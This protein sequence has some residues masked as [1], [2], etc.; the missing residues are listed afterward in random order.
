[1]LN[2][3]AKETQQRLNS[4]VT[5][6]NLVALEKAVHYCRQ[7]QGTGYYT[8]LERMT[9]VRDKIQRAMAEVNLCL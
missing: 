1:M 9:S 7:A 6:I 8:A 2:V 3:Q 5:Q 4:M